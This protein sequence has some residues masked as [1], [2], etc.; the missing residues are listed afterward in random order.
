MTEAAEELRSNLSLRRVA[1][2]RE[3]P[4][5]SVEGYWH[6]W[7]TP[8]SYSGLRIAR[9]SWNAGRLIEQLVDQ[10]NASGPSAGLLPSTAGMSLNGRPTRGQRLHVLRENL[11]RQQSGWAFGNRA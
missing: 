5:A 6:R 3:I 8:R 4:T 7:D 2:Y 9:S 10:A 11:I 1:F